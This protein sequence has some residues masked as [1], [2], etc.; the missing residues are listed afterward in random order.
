MFA[1]GGRGVRVYRWR[2]TTTTTLSKAPHRPLPN[3]PSIWSFSKTPTFCPAVMDVC[4]M[5]KDIS[6]FSTPSLRR[7]FEKIPLPLQQPRAA[8]DKSRHTQRD[9]RHESW[10]IYMHSKSFYN[11]FCLWNKWLHMKF[12]RGGVAKKTK[13]AKHLARSV[14]Y[15]RIWLLL[16]AGCSP[17][18][19]LGGCCK[20]SC[21]F[22]AG[23]INRGP[24]LK[25]VLS[26][27]EHVFP[28][29]A[30]TLF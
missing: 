30:D 20:L 5:L 9:L 28:G 26:T 15:W 10:R 22:I 1:P 16:Q 29:L 24:G 7:W 19:V 13:T 21:P 3:P 25:K 17:V 6:F 2:P 8:T 27:V 11:S 4:I 23:K 12:G 14:L 18:K